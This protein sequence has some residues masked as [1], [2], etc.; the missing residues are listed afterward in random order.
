MTEYTRKEERDDVLFAFH[1]AYKRPT[2]EQIVTW[3]DRY[4]EFAE[5]IR[6]HAAISRDWA[7]S[8]G[9][10]PIEADETML[11][12]AFSNVLNV[13]YDAETRAAADAPARVAKSFHEMLSEHGKEIYQLASELDIARSVL[14]DLF[15]GWMLAPIRSRLANAIVSAFR[16][17][18]VAFDDALAFALQ[19][20]RFGH[21]KAD[22]APIVTPRSCDEIIRESNMSAERKRYWLE[23]G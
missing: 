2:A 19:N 16:I 23:E 13:L 5:D 14:A 21:A 20:P 7:A 22:S 15:N 10:P 6:A 11:A 8:E 4:P 17:T 3:T 1:Q 12:R 18:R 9:L